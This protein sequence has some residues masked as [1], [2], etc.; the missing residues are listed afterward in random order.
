MLRYRLR[1]LLILMAFAPA[2][3]AGAWCE[4]WATAGIAA[5][6]LYVTVTLLVLGVIKLPTP[7]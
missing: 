1:T 3:I 4:P 7:P 2:T 5:F 6:F